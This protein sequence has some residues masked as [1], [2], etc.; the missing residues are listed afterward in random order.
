[1]KLKLIY[2]DTVRVKSRNLLIKLLYC[3]IFPWFLTA[4]LL[5]FSSYIYSVGVCTLKDAILNH[6]IS[7]I[8][9]TSLELI[10]LKFF[11]ADITFF[12]KANPSTSL[13]LVINIHLSKCIL[14][15]IS[16]EL[17]FFHF[18]VFLVVLIF[19]I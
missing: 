6:F 7:I 18:P 13:F 11:I 17:F 19:Q 2:C 1:M 9:T 10:T 16:I 4:N 15:V 3:F 12:C 8:S 5:T 14:L